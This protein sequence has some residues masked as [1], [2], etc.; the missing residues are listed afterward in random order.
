ML[1]HLHMLP[2]IAEINK[3]G[4]TVNVSFLVLEFQNFHAF[5]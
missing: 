1:I 3:L 5:E 4:L 2:Y